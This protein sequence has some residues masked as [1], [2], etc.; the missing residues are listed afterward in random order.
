METC[1]KKYKI[2]LVGKYNL[3]VYECPFC[4]HSVLDE[5]HD[6]IIGFADSPYGFVKIIECPKCFE[7]YYSH[8]DWSDLRAFHWSIKRG[9]QKHFKET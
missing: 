1:D 7:K 2:P 8:A 3:L 5:L 9:E 4:G 6:N